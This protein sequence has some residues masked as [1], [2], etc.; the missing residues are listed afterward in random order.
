V[1]RA[2]FLL[3]CSAVASCTSEPI[4]QTRESRP[5]TPHA[6]VAQV[7]QDTVESRALR[8]SLGAA[9]R[10][11]DTLTISLTTGHLVRFVNQSGEAP[12]G[13]QY[14][15]RFGGGRFE[16]IERSGGETYP[17]AVFVNRQTGQRVTVGREMVFAPDSQRFV[18]TDDDWNNCTDLNQPGMRIWRMTDSI[19]V[20]EWALEPFDC[21][22]SF[23]G[24]GPT[25]PKW[26]GSDTLDFVRNEM[27]TADTAA[28]ILK[29]VYSK[30]PAQAFR[31]SKG[32]RVRPL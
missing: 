20:L 19:P 22:S 4:R 31:D 12:Y 13:Y 24:W 21:R 23:N 6:A 2:R 3:Y 8:C 14:V 17:L 18:A 28:V 29:P 15:G 5:D 9:V 26:R 16:V 10:S 25:S 11:G 32:W 30:R 7:C 27:R 1:N